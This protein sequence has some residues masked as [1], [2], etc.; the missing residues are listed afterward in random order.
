MR[1]LRDD[2]ME[3]RPLSDK[4]QRWWMCDFCGGMADPINYNFFLACVIGGTIGLIL[5]L[6]F[7]A[8][9]PPPPKGA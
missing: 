1:G 6:I 2:D 9:F 8:N 4:I 3:G 7:F 5:A